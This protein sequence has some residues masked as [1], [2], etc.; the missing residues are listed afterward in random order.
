MGVAG[1][2]M[3]ECS[4]GGVDQTAHVETCL[5]LEYVPDVVCAQKVKCFCDASLGYGGADCNE[6]LCANMCAGHG[7]CLTKQTM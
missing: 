2:T 1:Q 7:E 5:K 3:C 6:P 4:K